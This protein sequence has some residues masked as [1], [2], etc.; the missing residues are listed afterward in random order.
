MISLWLVRFTSWI[1]SRFQL[2]SQ[3]GTKTDPKYIA[4]AQTRR[5]RA[6]PMRSEPRSQ[7]GLHE[8]WSGVSMSSQR[9][10][11]WGLNE[12]WYRIGRIPGSPIPSVPN[13]VWYEVWMRSEWG[14]ICSLPE[15]TPQF[16]RK[17]DLIQTSFRPHS[18]LMRSEWWPEHSGVIRAH[19]D[20]IQTSWGWGGRNILRWVG[21]FTGSMKIWLKSQ[22]N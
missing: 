20:L 6:Y 18:D 15:G 14:L 7:W 3:I 10:L 19:S 11:K 21:I 2:D 9:G 17:W 8:V 13:Q 12:V 1:V 22:E 4:A 5:S 16:S